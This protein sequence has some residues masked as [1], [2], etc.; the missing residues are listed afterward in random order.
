MTTPWLAS[1]KDMPR[2]KDMP[3]GTAWGL[4]DKDAVRD[5]LGTLNFLTHEVVLNAKKEIQAG[6][7]VVLKWDNHPLELNA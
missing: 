1:W 6:G 5:E 3:H 7:S 2:V 4:F